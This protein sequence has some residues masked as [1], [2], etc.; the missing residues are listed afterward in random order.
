MGRDREEDEELSYTDTE[1]QVSP[2]PSLT[3]PS[4]VVLH[5]HSPLPLS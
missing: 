1:L 2:T 3:P 5:P 4:Q